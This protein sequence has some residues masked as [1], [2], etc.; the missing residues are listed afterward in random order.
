MYFEREYWRK[1]LQTVGSVNT[2]PANIDSVNPKERELLLKNIKV[3]DLVLDYGVGGGRL[4]PVYNEIKPIVQGWDI[5]PYLELINNQ[6]EKYP[7]FQYSHLVSDVDIWENNYEDKQFDVIVCFSV[8]THIRP[9]RTQK[10][11]DEL[12][13][14]GKVLLLSAYDDAPLTITDESYCFLHDY[15]KLFEQYDVV[16]KFKINKFSYFTII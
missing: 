5:A 4:F 16:D 1:R 11:L 10:T 6:K 9:E 7:S 13:R 2:S 8:F 14:I 12:M 15:Q 3:H